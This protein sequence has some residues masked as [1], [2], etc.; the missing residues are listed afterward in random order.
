VLKGRK[1]LLRGQEQVADRIEF[2]MFRY[3]CHSFI[4]EIEVKSTLSLKSTVL[5]SAG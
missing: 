1:P 4:S 3:F 2:R 5:E